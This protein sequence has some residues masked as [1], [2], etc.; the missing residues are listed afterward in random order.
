MDGKGKQKKNSCHH[1]QS[2]YS[3]G[4]YYR[5]FSE[6][7][8]ISGQKNKEQRRIAF[9]SQGLVQGRPLYFTE[10]ASQVISLSW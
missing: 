3:V 1:H 8:N 2:S 6:S 5:S 7:F 9:S 10:K 4:I